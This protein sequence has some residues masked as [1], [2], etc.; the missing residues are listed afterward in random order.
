MRKIVG[1]WPLLIALSISQGAVAQGFPNLGGLLGGGGNAGVAGLING[2]MG[3]ILQSLTAG[4][5]QQRQQAIPQDAARGPRGQLRVGLHPNQRQ[6][7]ANALPLPLRL[8]LNL[9][10]LKRLPM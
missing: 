7:I 10:L 6:I 4:E 8:P 9:R 2:L 3:Q 5:Q 1:F